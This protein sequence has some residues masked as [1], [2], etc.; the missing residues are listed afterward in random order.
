MSDHASD[1]WDDE[2]YETLLELLGTTMAMTDPPP[3]AVRQ[4][5][6]RALGW[7][8]AAADLA[9]LSFDSTTSAAGAGMRSLNT[10][11]DLVFE[12]GSVSIEVTI[13]PDSATDE[14]LVAGAVGGSAVTH[15]WLLTPNQEPL[16]ITVDPNGYFHAT[17]SASVAALRLERDTDQPVQTELFSIR[18]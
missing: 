18:T 3:D 15:L 17:T 5:A 10:T 13:E 1:E 9:E 8:L 14:M 6:Q 11:R 12:L 7:D 2:L 4:S 16:S